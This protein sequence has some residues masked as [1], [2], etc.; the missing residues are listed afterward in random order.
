VPHHL[1]SLFDA[2]EPSGKVGIAAVK[3]PLDG[4]GR[5]AGDDE[6]RFDVVVKEIL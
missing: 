1:P 3:S 5:R 4:L 2:S 6:I